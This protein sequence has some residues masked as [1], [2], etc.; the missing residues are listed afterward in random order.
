MTRAIEAEFRAPAL[1]YLQAAQGVQVDAPELVGALVAFLEQDY[2]RVLERAQA[3][4]DRIPWSFE[5]RVHLGRA[6]RARADAHRDGGDYE[7]ALAD[8]RRAEAALREAVA[9]ARSD[10]EAHGALCSL[11]SEMMELEY[12]QRL[13]PEEMFVRAEK[14]CADALASDPSDAQTLLKA[15]DINWRWAMH[16]TGVGESPLAEI[17]KAIELAERALA[18]EYSQAYAHDNLGIGFAMLGEHEL[19][20]GGDP[21]ASLQKAREHLRWIL[22]RAPGFVTAYCNLTAASL[23]AAQYEREHGRDPSPHIETAREA[24]DTG[25]QVRLHNCLF[26]GRSETEHEAALYALATGS[27]PSAAVERALEAV[28][29]LRQRNPRLFHNE[30][31]AAR[32]WLVQAAHELEQERSPEPALTEAEAAVARARDLSSQDQAV[33]ELEAEIAMLRART[34]GAGAARHLDQSATSFA[35]AVA[36]DPHDARLL[37]R[38]ARACYLR[39]EAAADPVVAR[40]R[41]REG[42]ALVRKALEIHPK[43]AE[44][45]VLEGLFVRRLSGPGAAASESLRK[46][47]ELNPLLQRAYPELAAET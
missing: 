35:E 24:I 6:Y 45:W 46:G 18:D 2:D 47:L 36:R 8:Y 19:L 38:A 29:D 7:A 32:L 3:A 17:R 10:P 33:P 13:S 21:R 39:A 15:S 34:G 11:F 12:T 16:L 31:T 4:A 1:E 27:D 20:S 26:S 5:A 44:A 40:R 28:G 14:S 30:T 9:M 22:D 41:R 23:L 37:V 25:L 42:M 43:L